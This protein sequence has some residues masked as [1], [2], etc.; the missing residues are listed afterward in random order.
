MLLYKIIKTTTTTTRFSGNTKKKKR[1][2]VNKKNWQASL[3]KRTVWLYAPTI[4]EVFNSNWISFAWCRHN[5]T[6]HS[7]TLLLCNTNTYTHIQMYTQIPQNTTT[8]TTSSLTHS[9]SNNHGWGTHI[10]NLLLFV[11]YN[12]RW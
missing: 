5:T 1:Y 3:F 7:S 6:Q 11:V 8:T 12:L 9:T 2:R 4:T 10:H